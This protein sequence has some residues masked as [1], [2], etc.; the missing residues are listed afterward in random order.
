MAAATVTGV[1]RKHVLGDRFLYGASSVVFA[2]N[3]DTWAVPL[4]TINLICMTP[5]TN[6]AFGFTTSYSAATGLTTLTLVAA[7]GL[8]F[9]GGAIGNS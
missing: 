7:S 9:L 4:K 2:N 1:F 6:V 8:T 5:T 3:G